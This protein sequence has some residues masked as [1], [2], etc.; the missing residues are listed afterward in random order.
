MRQFDV[1][2]GC[3]GC[4][5]DR[6][7]FLAAGC[8]AC[9]GVAG[10]FGPRA[11]VRAAGEDRKLRIRIVYSLHAPVQP[12]PDW[13]NVGFDFHP[14]MQRINTELAQRCPGFEFLPSLAT[15]PEQAQKILDE[16]RSAAIDGYLVYQLNC[17]NR[18]VQTI[19]K[20]DKPV[21]YA[22][23]QYAGSGGFL[24]YTAGFLRAKTPNLGFVAS[25]RIEDVAE[26]VKC[27]DVVKRGGSAADFVAATARVRGE[28]TPAAGGLACTPDPLQTL[29][30]DECVRR[31][32]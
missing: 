2:S 19:V 7:K 14:V 6:R 4:L 8:A 16:D 27:F 3:A 15:G 32:K 21:L 1:L 28:R 13:P 30:T 10:L 31:M 29:A 26:A 5:V 23:L 25:S 20:S 11:A 24:V 9:A 22:D 18:V 12:G 17:W